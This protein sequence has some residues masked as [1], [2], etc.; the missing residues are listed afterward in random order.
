[1]SDFGPRFS[2]VVPTCDR[3]DALAE[4]LER[5]ADSRDVC[6]RSVE[7]IVTDDSANGSAASALGARFP[8]VRWLDGP[9]TGPAANRNHGAAHAT[10]EW[11]VFI[12]DDCLPERGLLKAYDQAAGADGK[13]QVLEG[14]TIVDREKRH[15][16]EMAP[17]NDSGGNLWSCNFAI[18]R[19]VFLVMGGFDE[20]FKT[21]AMEDKDLSLRLKQSGIPARFI[22]DAIVVHPWRMTD[23]KRHT[24]QHAAAVFKF[25]AIHHGGSFRKELIR[26]HLWNI[27]RYYWKEFPNEVRQFGLLAFRCQP[28]KLWSFCYYGWYFLTAKTD[29]I[30]NDADA[31]H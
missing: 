21:P 25:A 26:T 30:P 23:F 19:D 1:M 2:V 20:R 31:G 3:M 11:L 8:E 10:G 4:C 17:V 15:P 28:M 13:I 27:A 24:R 29:A 6:G 22:P 18:R 14:R 5:L 12:D 9:R 16:F 7:I